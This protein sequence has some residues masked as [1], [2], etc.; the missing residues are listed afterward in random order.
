MS[1]TGA[2]GGARAAWA[3]TGWNVERPTAGRV[4]VIGGVL[5]FVLLALPALLSAYWINVLTGVAVFAVVAL[6]LNLLFGRVGLVSLGQIALLAV[7]S[8]IAARLF[9]LTS[10]PFPIVL[11]LAGLFTA[12]IGTLLGLPAL[13]LGGLNL[14]LITL[15]FAGLIAIVVPQQLS[16]GSKA[17]GIGLGLTAYTLGMRHAFDASEIDIHQNNIVARSYFVPNRP[18]ACDRR[19]H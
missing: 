6:G 14:A 17:F 4:I 15:M 1:A 19:S 11:L 5:L 2:P 7:A 9:F 13:R 16:V 3:R 8:W 12:L 10:L 18:F